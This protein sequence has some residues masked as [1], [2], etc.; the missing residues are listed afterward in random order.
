MTK[1]DFLHKALSKLKLIEEDRLPAG[2]EAFN[3]LTDREKEHLRDLQV[4]NRELK[5]KELLIAELQSALD[6]RQAQCE[7]AELELAGKT[8]EFKSAINGEREEYRTRCDK[9]EKEFSAMEKALMDELQGLKEAVSRKDADFDRLNLDMKSAHDRRKADE[10]KIGALAAKIRDLDAALQQT[11]FSLEEKTKYITLT[12][13]ALERVKKESE[14]NFE[15]LSRRDREVNELKTSLESAKA[16]IDNLRTDLAARDREAAAREKELSSEPQTLKDAITRGELENAG[17]KKELA[18][19]STHNALLKGELETRMLEIKEINVFNKSSL[20]ALREKDEDLADLKD[21]LEAARKELDLSNAESGE[22]A[23][24][25]ESAARLAGEIKKLEQDRARE[26]EA[27]NLELKNK[28]Q[29]IFGLQSELA[30]RREERERLESEL[31]NKTADFKSLLN[32]EREEYRARGDGLEKEFSG[33]EKTLITELQNAKETAGNKEA[34]IGRLSVELKSARAG[35]ETVRKELDASRAGIIELEKFKDGADKYS[36][37][38]KKLKELHGA[39]LKA[40]QAELNGKEQLL[41]ALNC[42]CVKR[43]EERTRLEL[44]L[45]GKKSDFNS[46]LN[47][48]REASRAERDSLERDSAA[49]EQE[50]A[51]KELNA[52][53]DR[54]IELEKLKDGANKYSNEIKKLKELHA[55]ELKALQVALNGK[56]QLL[57]SLNCERAKRQ[58]ERTR[59]ELELTKKGAEFKSLLNKEREV[60]RLERYSLASEFSARE[61]AL[62]SE[63]Q[64]LK[65]ALARG[66]LEN[67]GLKKELAAASTHNALLKEELKALTLEITK[68]SVFNKSSISALREKDEDLAVSNERLEAARKELDLSNARLGELEAFKEGA[69][70]LAGEIK[71]LEVELKNKT[72]DI[73]KLQS[74]LYKRQEERVSAELELAGKKSDFKSLLNKEREEYRAR[75]DILEKEF[76]AGEK[77]LVTELQSLR[78]AAGQKEAEIGRL[79]AEL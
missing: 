38:I 30:K 17:L 42:E 74:E 64:A 61:K 55:A 66:E 10:E 27:L 16:V 78:E 52:S 28:D 19:A 58:E 50:T 4:L 34:E 9:L 59:L 63:P 13:K 73:V 8:S 25:R 35:Q 1:K 75:C 45:A 41:A 77:A 48:E 37:E 32:K 46:L 15:K 31:I 3:E 29:V 39:E 23:A 7:R 21:R 57:A 11:R 53:R 54:I 14:T 33:R 22:L 56:E 12:V 36:N 70:G 62:S 18:T 6:K 5:N 69:A 71:K 68:I 72:Q 67:A 2:T 60:Y 43:Q 49:R 24:S 79:G 47:R 76:S 20:S 26:A 51:G 44:E 40:L 65:D